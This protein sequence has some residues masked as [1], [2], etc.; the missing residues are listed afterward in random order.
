MESTVY[1]FMAPKQP[2]RRP[3]I[4]PTHD[5]LDQCTSVPET[6]SQVAATCSDGG[7]ASRSPISI[8]ESP[9]I[10]QT[11]MPHDDVLPKSTSSDFSQEDDLQEEVYGDEPQPAGGID[12]IKPLRILKGR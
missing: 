7:T 10:E 9:P 8:S 4:V 2:P 11:E 1:R 5:M 3:P 12:D 6:V